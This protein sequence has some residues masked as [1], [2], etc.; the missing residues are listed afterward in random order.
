MYNIVLTEDSSK[1]ELL[2]GCTI[3]SNLRWHKQV[4]GL[5][6][7]L[8]KSLTGL[9]HL[10]YICS[11]DTR[12]VITEGI[13]N[14]VLVY[15]LPLYGGMDKGQIKNLQVIKNN[16]AQLVCSVQP[17]NRSPQNLDVW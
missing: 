16:A 12:K 4:E 13:F 11:F 7:K 1:S 8:R 2:L 6:D 15:C 17:S 9:L 10:K 3:Q 5:I 14:S